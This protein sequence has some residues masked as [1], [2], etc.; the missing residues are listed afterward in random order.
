MVITSEG[1]ALLTIYQVYSHDLTEFREFGEEDV[2]PNY[3]WDCLF[4]E[5]DLATNELLFE[6]RVSDHHA[7]NET[8]REIGGD[9]TK[10]SPWDWYHINSIQKDE[11]GNYMISAR[12]THSVTYIDGTSGDIIWILGGKR[13]MFEDL[14]DGLATKF[15]NQH[16]ARMMPLNTFPTLL[17]D[18]IKAMG[19]WEG[20]NTKDGVTTQL[21]TMFDNSAEDGHYTDKISHGLVLEVSYPAVSDAHKDSVG[22]LDDSSELGKRSDP[23][24]LTYTARLVRSYDHPQ[25]I[26]SSSQGSMQVLPNKDSSQDPKILLGYGFNAVWTEFS[27]NGEVLCDTHFASNYSWERG[28]VQS[29][30]VFKFPWVGHPTDPPTSVLGDDTIF[31]SW[32]GATEVKTWVLQHST[33]YGSDNDES[34][35]DIVSVPKTKFETAI[36]F[37]E[38]TSDRYLRILALDVNGQVIGVSREVDLGWTVGLISTLPKMAFSGGLAP[39]KLLMLFACNVTILFVLME[40]YKRVVTWYTR[41]KYARV[42]LAS[43]A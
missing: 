40:A 20:E 11:H 24:S 22:I 21:I 26:I 14:S 30:R 10:E 35:R 1:T 43:D 12:Y 2:E 36:E 23:R 8:F 25:G 17:N 19:F 32:N 9:G 4:Q 37:E 41:R 33:Q 34:W 38:D 27:A 13:N 42:R 29:Y 31:V 28:D 6:W 18:D 16:H 5:I 3:I 15:A 7:V 39:L